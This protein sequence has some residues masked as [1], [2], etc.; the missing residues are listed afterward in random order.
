MADLRMPDINK[1][2]LAG[3][4][5][6]DPELQHIASGTAL[7]KMGMV[8][9][10]KFKTKSGEMKEETVF[11]DITIWGNAAEYC[12]ENMSKGDPVF[13]EGK[14]KTEEW[15]DKESGNMRNKMA[16]TAHVVSHLSWKDNDGAGKPSKPKPSPVDE[17]DTDDQIPF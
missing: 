12:G 14:L 2:M 13:M 15:K 5:T 3:R 17:P 1:V 11:V 7:C 8:Y 9:S 16:V 6:R 4:L 10:K